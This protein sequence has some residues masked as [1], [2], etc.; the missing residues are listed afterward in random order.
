[1]LSLLAIV[2]P[3]IWLWLPAATV[4]LKFATALIGFILAF[5]LLARRI[6]IWRRRRR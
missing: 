5:S 4:V 2:L 6:R 1:M 3:I